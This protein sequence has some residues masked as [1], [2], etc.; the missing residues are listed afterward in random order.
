MQQESPQIQEIKLLET[1][2]L[3]KVK[4]EDSSEESN[5]NSWTLSKEIVIVV[6]GAAVILA[7]LLF[8]VKR[9]SKYHIESAHLL[10][11]KQPYY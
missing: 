9:R 8:M 5:N 7:G 11:N 4:E 3:E 10:E 2:K 1:V 6:V